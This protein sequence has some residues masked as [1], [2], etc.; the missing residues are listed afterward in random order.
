MSLDHNLDH[1]L[2]HNLD[3]SLDQRWDLSLDL[4]LDHNL[5]QSLDHNQ[6]LSLDLGPEQAAVDLPSTGRNLG[7]DQISCVLD[8]GV[9]SEG[10]VPQ[11]GRRTGTRRD[12]CLCGCCCRR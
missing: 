4:S 5:D 2:D 11:T 1:K 9:H 8:S 10:R 12:C 3:L 7:Q 6:D